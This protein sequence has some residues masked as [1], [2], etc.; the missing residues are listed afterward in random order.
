MCGMLV[1]SRRICAQFD[2]SFTSFSIAWR[3]QSHMIMTVSSVA[4]MLITDKST[5]SLAHSLNMTGVLLHQLATCKHGRQSKKTVGF[6]R[7][8]GSLTWTKRADH[9]VD[10]LCNT[11]YQSELKD[12][13]RKLVIFWIESSLQLGHSRWSNM[14]DRKGT[15]NSQ[16]P[17][18]QTMTARW[19]YTFIAKL[20]L[21]LYPQEI[22]KKK[23]EN[24]K[25]FRC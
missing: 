24:E 16:V 15:G 21:A 12:D 1:C 22:H 7:V 18:P 19:N 13:K 3:K 17:L 11:F 6:R 25:R 8:P 2:N 5:I 4:C 20:C 10:Y 9:S 23:M 14:A